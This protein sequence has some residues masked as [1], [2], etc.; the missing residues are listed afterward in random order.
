M[1]N[2]DKQF[3]VDKKC[4]I[5]IFVNQGSK[6]NQLANHIFLIALEKPIFV[7]QVLWTWKPSPYLKDAWKLN[8]EN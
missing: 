1:R 3:F 4:L 6:L 7:T 2:F 5:Y 8:K